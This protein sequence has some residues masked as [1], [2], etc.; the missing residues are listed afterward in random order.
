MFAR[1][2]AL[3]ERPCSP[4]FNSVDLAAVR[5]NRS[6]TLMELAIQDLSGWP[7]SL[8][9]R[10]QCYDLLYQNWRANSLYLTDKQDK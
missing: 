8:N 6:L 5:K 10:E 9:A 1:G 4:L 7:A 3:S 2:P